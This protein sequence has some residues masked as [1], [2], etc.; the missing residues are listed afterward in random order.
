MGALLISLAF[1]FGVGLMAAGRSRA[2]GRVPV[3]E[4]VPQ[5][6]IGELEAG[7]F[8]VVGRVVPLETSP[9]VIDGTACVF[10]EHAEYRVLGSSLVPVMKEVDHGFVAHAFHLDDGTGQVLVDPGQAVVDAVTM[11]EDSGVVAERRVRAG[12]EIELVATFAAVEGE[13]DGG[14]YRATSV[15]FEPRADMV[16]PPR[17][18]YRTDPAMM[19]PGDEIAAFLRG[20]GVLVLLVSAVMASLAFL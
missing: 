1:V 20:A 8:R 4:A 18:S 19:V 3:L 11:V 16:G 10:L 5:C 9:S 17:I 15:A 14:P 6:V 13:R 12:E 7:R 2:R